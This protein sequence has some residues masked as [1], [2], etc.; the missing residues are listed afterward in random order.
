VV[1]P[2]ETLPLTGAITVHRDKL[3]GLAALVLVVAALE[4]QLQWT[5][6]LM[7]LILVSQLV[8]ILGL[9]YLFA[10]TLLVIALFIFVR[11]KQNSGTL[12]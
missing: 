10:G 9:S 4:Q 5:L 6:L 11:V 1:F 8:F 3:F 2:V 7:P 12:A